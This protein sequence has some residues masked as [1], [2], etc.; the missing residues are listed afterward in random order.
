MLAVVLALSIALIPRVAL[1]KMDSGPEL[2]PPLLAPQ[3][4]ASAGW[5]IVEEPITDWQP[6]FANPSTT[7]NVVLARGEQRVVVFIAWYRQQN[8]ERKLISSAN[9]LVKSEDKAWVQVGRDNR[10]VMLADQS[11][12]VRVGSLHS[13]ATGLGAEP[14]RLRVWHWYWIDGRPITSDHLG[15]LWLALSRL[16]GQLDDS[17]AV[18]V[19]A[20]E[21]DGE[22]AMADYLASAGGGIAALLERAV[23]PAPTSTK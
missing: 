2:P 10:Q 16:S 13:V 15:K 5:Q 6:A 9:A 7:A 1:L 14:K 22:A 23:P 18:F 8:Y 4:L 17:A 20:Q 12:N 3:S 21:P 11:I 19:Y